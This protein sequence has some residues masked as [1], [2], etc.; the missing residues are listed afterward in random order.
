MKY[1]ILLLLSGCG[2]DHNIKGD[3]QFDDIQ[4]NVEYVETQVKQVDGQFYVR[5]HVNGFTVACLAVDSSTLYPNAWVKISTANNYRVS[6]YTFT[7]IENC[8]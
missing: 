4:V 1:L 7:E 3:V 6:D 2:I 5:R 8:L